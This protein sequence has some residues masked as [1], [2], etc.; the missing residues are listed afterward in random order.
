MLKLYVPYEKWESKLRE[1][2]AIKTVKNEHGKDQWK[3][4]YRGKL[5]NKT[6]IEILAKY[7]SEIRGLYN[8]YSLACDACAL[9]KFASLMKYS[10]L[11]T[12]GAKYRT[13]VSKIKSKYVEN[14]NFTIH[15]TAKS[16][17]R[18]AVLYNIQ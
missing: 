12:F 18:Q 6:D 10:L 7:N 1:Y 3:A 5:I 17:N 13:K 8:Y 15:Y 4:I 9:S 14:I 16:G 2:G 11:K